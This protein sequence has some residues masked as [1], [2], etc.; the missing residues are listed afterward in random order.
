MFILCLLYSRSWS[1]R[2]GDGE[3]FKTMAP[4]SKVFSID[5]IDTPWSTDQTHHNTVYTKILMTCAHGDATR[6][7]GWA[8]HLAHPKN[9]GAK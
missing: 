8:M 9:A 7:F 5:V 2:L 4:V 1:I 3:L 6:Y